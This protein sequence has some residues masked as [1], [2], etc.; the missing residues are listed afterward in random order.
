MTTQELINR[1][2]EMPMDAN[3]KIIQEDSSGERFFDLETVE[4][5]TRLLMTTEGIEK[6]ETV[7]IGI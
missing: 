6:V 2:Q 1:L 4:N 7:I 5:M 3:V